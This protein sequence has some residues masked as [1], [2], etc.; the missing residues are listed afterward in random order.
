MSTICEF[1][2]K[3]FFNKKTLN[4]HQKKCEKLEIFKKYFGA[5]EIKQDI[6]KYCEAKEE[7]IYHC[8]GCIE[9]FNNDEELNIHRK[10][11]EEVKKNVK[12]YIKLI[13]LIFKKKQLLEC[14]KHELEDSK[15]DAVEKLLF[16]KILD[17]AYF[18]INCENEEYFEK[19]MGDSH[20]IT[21]DIH[22]SAKAADKI[23]ERF[24]EFYFNNYDI[25]AKNPACL[26]PKI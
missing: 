7:V 17:V 4:K 1:C 25:I 24:S 2:D 3:V 20:D 10:T 26:D 18:Y 19:L 23:L 11:C 22:D 9:S 13:K 5:N 16:P 21:T 6:G 14:M 15:R 8:S 12:K